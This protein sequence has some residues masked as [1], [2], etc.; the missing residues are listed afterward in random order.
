MH[1]VTVSKVEKILTY[2]RGT[3]HI[4]TGTQILTYTR[5]QMKDS[6]PQVFH[7]IY[8]KKVWSTVKGENQNWKKAWIAIYPLRKKAWDHNYPLR[9]KSLSGAFHILPVKEKSLRCLS[10]NSLHL[11]VIYPRVWKA[12]GFSKILHWMES[13]WVFLLPNNYFM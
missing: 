6:L 10:R 12:V 9:K 11:H 3:Q 13:S 4:V 7:Y 8:N 1:R 2:T 5:K